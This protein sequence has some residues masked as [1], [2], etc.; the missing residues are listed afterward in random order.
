MHFCYLFIVQNNNN[1]RGVEQVEI[2][3]IWLWITGITLD[4]K[5]NNFFNLK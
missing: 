5:I 4:F 1:N 2:I 3:V